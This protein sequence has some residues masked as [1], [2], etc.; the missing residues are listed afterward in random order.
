MIPNQDLEKVVKSNPET[1]IPV[2]EHIKFFYSERDTFEV[3]PESC[4]LEKKWL[5][6]SRIKDYS[7]S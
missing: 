2:W 1:V 3:D 4:N 7:L 6:S 5:E